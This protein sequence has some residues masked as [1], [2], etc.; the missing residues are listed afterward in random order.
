MATPTLITPLDSF[1]LLLFF[2]PVTK[3]LFLV[4]A[5]EAD[6]KNTFSTNLLIVIG[7]NDLH[8][9]S[10]PPPYLS[11]QRQKLDAQEY[12]IVKYSGTEIS[13]ATSGPT[14]TGGLPPC[15]VS[16]EL[17][18]PPTTIVI[19]TSQQRRCALRHRLGL[20]LF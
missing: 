5:M 11:T 8:R 12:V 14:R 20:E 9:H 18:E 10:L 15:S 16:F 4:P 19:R 3:F 7:N 1:S 6:S 13:T 2:S 17:H